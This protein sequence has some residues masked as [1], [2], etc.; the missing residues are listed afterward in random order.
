[1]Q[2]VSKFLATVAW[3][4]TARRWWSIQQAYLIRMRHIEEELGLYAVRYVHFLDNSS[5]LAGS[6]LR[7]EYADELARRARLQAI[8]P[9]HQRQGVQWTMS[10]LPL[11]VLLAWVAYTVWLALS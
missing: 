11:I 7:K 8:L 5:A 4:F 1:M 9:A 2:E 6:G 10:F 3:F